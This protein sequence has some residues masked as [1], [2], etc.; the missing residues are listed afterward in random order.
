[1]TSK[2]WHTRG[3]LNRGYKKTAWQSSRN[4]V[5]ASGGKGKP[6]SAIDFLL[7]D[8]R[9]SERFLAPEGRNYGRKE[10]VNNE[11]KVP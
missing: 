1:M 3:W 11:N 5:V 9:V 2:F 6:L 8:C 4:P 10:R 7:G